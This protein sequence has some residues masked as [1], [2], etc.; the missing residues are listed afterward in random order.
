M[1]DGSLPDPEGGNDYSTSNP[2]PESSKRPKTRQTISLADKYGTRI[3][4]R[5]GDHSHRGGSYCC[6]PS[7]PDQHTREEAYAERLLSMPCLVLRGSYGLIRYPVYGHG[8]FEAKHQN[9]L[10]WL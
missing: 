6:V 8:G 3:D 7:S 4:H 1:D 10:R 9:H 5:M 2:H